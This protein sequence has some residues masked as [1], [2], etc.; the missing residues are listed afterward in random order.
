M[1]LNCGIVGLPNVGKSTLFKALTSAPAEAANYP[2]CTIDPNRGI[3]DVPDHRI[4][5]IAEIVEPE[6]V[7]SSTVEF[8]DIA[9]LVK[10]ASKGEGL[11]NQFLGHIRQVS[12]IVHVVRCFEDS[13]VVHV[14][15][16]ID[17]I[18]D[19][20]TI[21]F[22]LALSDLETVEKRLSNLDKSIKSHDK[23]VS[24]HAKACKPLLEQLKAHLEEG[25]RAS[26]IEFDQEEMELLSDL[27][28]ITFKEVI[29]L[30]NVDEE[31]LE[32]DSEYVKQ[33]KDH[34]QQ[35]GGEVLKISGKLESEL[36]EIESIEE[37]KE[38][39]DSLGIQDSGLNTLIKQVYKTLGLETYFTAG[40]KEVRAWT[41]HKGWKAPK[42]ASVIHTDFERGFIKAEVYS[43]EDL[44][45][46]GTEA[47][48][49]E[50]GR[51]RIEGKEYIVQD[52]DIVH[53]RF[54][55]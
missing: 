16:K 36:A 40:K 55:V 18:S 26:L 11:G 38:F 21:N 27:H 53:F 50:A 28:L 49:K 35:E 29:Y 2:F 7:M 54:N 41:F 14:D 23:K 45:K 8:V 30:C 12:A 25:K 19:I 9:G 13:D 39:L 43:F 15:G 34:V 47:K 37:R 31:G 3:V 32:T 1:S 24:N 22:E 44:I 51:F 20:E 4:D 48:V 5:K 10:G 52:G 6:K 42:A 46:H 33:V 17:P